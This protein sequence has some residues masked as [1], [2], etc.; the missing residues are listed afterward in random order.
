MFK[1]IIILLSIMISVDAV[2]ELSFIEHTRI[3][4][5]INFWDREMHEWNFGHVNASYR[6][7]SQK[8]AIMVQVFD[9]VSPIAALIGFVGSTIRQQGYNNFFIDTSAIL[10]SAVVGYKL[11]S[12]ARSNYYTAVNPFLKQHGYTLYNDE[13]E[14]EAL[15]DTNE[16][17][18]NTS[19]SFFLNMAPIL[20]AGAVWEYCNYPMN[21]FYEKAACYHLAST[22]IQAGLRWYQ[23]RHLRKNLKVI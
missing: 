23:L 5:S 15:L 1:K 21:R 19:T 14:G 18:V 11:V 13:N 10:G 8:A 6:S 12:L 3:S 20:L 4:P 2:Q 9:Y 7:D 17:K 22:T 16:S